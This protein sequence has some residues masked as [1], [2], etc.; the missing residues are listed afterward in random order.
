MQHGPKQAV[1]AELGIGQHA[2][3]RD[4]T[5]AHLAEQR[6]RLAPLPLKADAVGNPRP[7]PGAVGQPRLGQVQRKGKPVDKRAD[8]WASQ[9]PDQ[10]AAPHGGRVRPTMAGPRRAR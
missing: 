4:A 7:H 8:V 2:R 9:H 1:V 6:Q 5:R 3:Q 10:A